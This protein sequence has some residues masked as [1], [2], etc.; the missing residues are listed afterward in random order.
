MYHEHGDA[1]NDKDHIIALD[2]L[3]S[4]P[5]QLKHKI[6]N[7]IKMTVCIIEPINPS[8]ALHPLDLRMPRTVPK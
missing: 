5:H 1:G 4:H 3:L 6:E 7:H 2:R 8:T